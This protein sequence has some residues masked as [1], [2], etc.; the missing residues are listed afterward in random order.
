MSK[1]GY[2]TESGDYFKKAPKREWHVKKIKSEFDSD[3]SND[4]F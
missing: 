1:G 3:D 4:M 2:I